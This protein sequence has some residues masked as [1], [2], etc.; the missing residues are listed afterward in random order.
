MCTGTFLTI[1]IGLS[2]D[3]CTPE[4]SCTLN[5]HSFYGAIFIPG[6]IICKNT[7]VF[8]F[9]PKKIISV[10]GPGIVLQFALSFSVGFAEP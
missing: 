6:L 8:F 1:L 3:V 9:P 7:L 10:Y 4:N 2:F 5:Q